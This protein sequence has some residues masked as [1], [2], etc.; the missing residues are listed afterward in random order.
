MQ[1]DEAQGAREVEEHRQANTVAQAAAVA[2][3]LGDDQGAT[4]AGRG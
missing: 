2:W 4:T 3:E 1:R